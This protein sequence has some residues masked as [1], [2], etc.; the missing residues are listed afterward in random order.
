MCVCVT[1]PQQSVEPSSV[2]STASAVA[3][4][5]VE[6]AELV[7]DDGDGDTEEAAEEAPLSATNHI[8]LAEAV[9]GLYPPSPTSKYPSLLINE[10]K[11]ERQEQEREKKRGKRYM[12][13][14]GVV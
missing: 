12:F 3:S 7:G 4:G 2:N 9:G 5:E 8:L 1:N 6:D 13:F 10:T 11:R 14:L